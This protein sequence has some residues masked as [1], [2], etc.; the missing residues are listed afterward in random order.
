MIETDVV[1]VGSGAAGLTAAI[2]ARALGMHVTVLE[3][4]PVFG[5]TTAL[6]GGALW[7]PCN[8]S[9]TAFGVQDSADD[10]RTYLKAVLGA[11]Y[12]DA[13]AETFIAQAPHMLRFMEDRMRLAFTPYALPDYESELPGAKRYRSLL[14]PA[15]D[16]RLLGEWLS[17]LRL[18][19]AQMMLFGSMQVDGADVRPLRN[20][21]RTWDGFRHSA[22][23]ISR[24]LIE[25]ARY[26]RGLR[27]T[28]GNA[29]AARLLHCA[30]ESGVSLWRNA[31]ALE[32]AGDGH[33]RIRTVLVL[34]DGVRTHVLARRGVVLATGG[35]GANAAMRA[36]CLPLADHHLSLQPEGNVGDGIR[37]GIAAG[38][39]RDRAH[40]GDCL[41]TP[42]SALRAANGDVLAYPHTFLDRSMPGCIAVAPDG[43]R[44]VNEGTSYQTFV[45]AMHQ[46]K[47]SK[48]HLVCTQRFLR[49]YGLGLAHPFPFSPARLIAAGYLISSPTLEGLAPKIGVDAAALADTVR[50]FD[51][52]AA[53]GRD[54]AFG[55]GVDAH[56][57]F[58]GDRDHLPN[59]GVGP[60]GPGPYFAVALHPGSLSTMGG[61][62]VDGN[63]QVLR[64]DRHPIAGLY[65]VG[66]DMNSVMRG[67]YPGGGSSLGP[68]MTFGYV[69]AMHLHETR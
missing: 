40:A 13:L 37:L 28:N 60:L 48:V 64:R 22:K 25:R 30:I 52:D 50:R 56:S 47:L 61:L 36:E 6:S 42:M 41:W 27:L 21:L 58:R 43:K 62:E 46:L 55:K 3:K 16:G 33:G 45:E 29:L 5:G 49:R 67:H 63:A 8:P 10:A 31:V 7:V 54:P 53:H 19:L 69:A 57:N 14:T 38:G 2:K 39:W 51:A 59:P 44:F 65:A 12:P 1:V 11:T 9:T 35:F 4:T 66:A 18:P 34:K 32:L 20:A 15:F 26:G 17:A 24:F 23:I 68:A